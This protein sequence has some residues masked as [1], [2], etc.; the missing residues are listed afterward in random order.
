[1]VA[2]NSLTLIRREVLPFHVVSDDVYTD[3]DRSF[4]DRPAIFLDAGADPRAVVDLAL[5]EATRLADLVN[6]VSVA[7]SES[8]IEPARVAGLFVD[9]AERLLQLLNLLRDR[10]GSADQACAR[11]A[12]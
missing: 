2:A 9:P 10:I 7:G 1:M 5:A 3:T 12:A 8:E 4:A 6:F 11:E